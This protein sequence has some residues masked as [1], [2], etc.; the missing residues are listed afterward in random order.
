MSQDLNLWQKFLPASLD[1]PSK[2]I[3]FLG[4]AG[5]VSLVLVSIA[6]SQILLAIAIIGFIWMMKRHKGPFPPGPSIIFPLLVY[7]G[8]TLIAILASSN[9]HVGLL[10]IKKFYLL[11]LVPIVPLIVRGQGRLT[12]IHRSIF[13]VAIISA[14]GGLAQ[15]TNLQHRISGFMSLSMTYSGLLMLALM[16]LA[17][18][19]FYSSRSSLKWTIPLAVSIVLALI[20]SQTRSALI[21]AIVGIVVL[22]LMRKPRAIV[23]FLAAI[24]VLFLFSPS[25]IKQRFRSGMDPA[26]ATTRGR[27]ELYWTS[28]RM[29]ADNPWLGVGPKNVGI[30]ALK[31][32][33]KN[34]FPD[35]LYQ[36]MHNNLRQIAAE[37]GIPGL[38]IWLW[39]MFRLIWDALRCYRYAC[40]NSF[41]EEKELRREAKI[42]SSAAIAAWVAL[43][44]AGIFE[45]N[46]GDSEVLTLFLFIVSAPYSF[47]IQRSEDLR[48]EVQG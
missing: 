2:K 12:W 18:Y 15:F 17:A 3:A 46:F 37:I 23:I 26:D 8:W 32:R 13:A 36:H 20:F 21:G 42:A 39:F 5:C 11:L 34:D 48:S 38:L 14:L 6:A 40:G 29:I 44:I 9:I 1:H 25:P 43:I 47:L 28:L 35:W 10:S 45:Y 19:A 33:G 41:P 24:L 27:I 22:V 31:Y 7:M 30:E 16:L 4:L